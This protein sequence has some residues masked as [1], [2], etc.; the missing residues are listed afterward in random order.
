MQRS[1]LLNIILVVFIVM[2]GFGLIMPLIPYYGAEYGAS[3]FLLGLLMAAYAV[4]QFVGAPLLG[5][6]SDRL[7]R[8]PLLV[9]SMAGT[10]LGFLLL[11]LADP[12]GRGLST[13]LS[14]NPTLELQN[15]VILGVMFFS[16]LIS[17]LTGGVITVANAYIA[18]VTDE[19]DRTQ[20]MG[21]LG[22]A[23]GLSFILGPV[24]GGVLSQWGYAVPA[25][26]A[27]GLAALNLGTVTG[28]L[29]ESLT[30][31]RKAELASQPKRP[32]VSLPA[33]IKS[34][35]KP[36]LGPLLTIRLF[37]SLAGALF[38]ALFTLWTKN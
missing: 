38:M 9:V 29:K 14:A 16:R 22:A 25:F 32:L 13:L 35:G 12:L 6:L 3:D 27:A 21:M 4:A 17:G 24:I 8:R 11:G 1:Q 5:R 37:V 31:E 36:R 33:M 10:A 18:D 26:V 34:L 30:A 28:V 15:A 19:R 20:G 2:L 7:G 23:F